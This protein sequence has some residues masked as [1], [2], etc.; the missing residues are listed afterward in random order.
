V[1]TDV[2]NVWHLKANDF[3]EKDDQSFVL[4]LKTYFILKISKSKRG[5]LFGFGFGFGLDYVLLKYLFV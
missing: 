2:D 5:I 3:G 1:K 4:A